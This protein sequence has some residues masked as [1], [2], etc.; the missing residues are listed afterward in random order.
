MCNT[1]DAEWMFKY[2]SSINANEDKD[3]EY[4]SNLALLEELD[5]KLELKNKLNSEEFVISEQNIAW[6]N[7]KPY[8]PNLTLL[9]PS[10]F[11]FVAF[12]VPALIK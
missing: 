6:D 3:E 11:I 10:L 7:V 9:V 12:I 5:K 2:A 4:P 1:N 8:E